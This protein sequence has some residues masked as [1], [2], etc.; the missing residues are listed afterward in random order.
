[1]SK[2][3]KNFHYSNK[4]HKKYGHNKTVRTVTIKGGKGH[5]KVTHYKK[6]K[7]THTVK[8]PLTVIEIVT[9][10]RGKFIPALFSDCTSTKKNRTYKN[11]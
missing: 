4:E 9:I 11:E 8:K 10:Q 3:L 1:M 2:S 6:G 5:K 7:K